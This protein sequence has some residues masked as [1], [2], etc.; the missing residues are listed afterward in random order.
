MLRSTKTSVALFSTSIME[1]PA[2][3][4]RERKENKLLKYI[5]FECMWTVSVPDENVSYST[6]A[7]ERI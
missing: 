2:H 5:Y 3:K 4:N 7:A 6:D 1:L